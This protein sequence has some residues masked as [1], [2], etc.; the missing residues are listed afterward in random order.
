[1]KRSVIVVLSVSWLGCGAA[2]T[3]QGQA[4]STTHPN[5]PG[6]VFTIVFENEAASDVLTPAA[7]FFYQLSQQ[8]G[9]ALAYS[10]STHPSLPNY[11]MMTSGSTNGI[12]TDNDPAQNISLAGPDNL[13]AQLDAGN[14]MWRAYMESM[15]SPCTMASS[16]NYSAHHD[17]FLYYAYLAG[18]AASCAQHVVDY[19]QNFDADLA[20]GIYRYMWITPNMCD[21]MHNCSAQIADAWL[22]T[23]VTKIQASDAY[24]KGGAIIILFDEGS[25]RAPGATANLPTLVVSPLTAPAFKTSTPFDHRSYL[26][27]IED[28]FDL[29][30]LATTDAVN[31]MDE[32]FT[33]PPPAAQ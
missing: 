20:S 30:R 5:V 24:K 16:G 19:D 18:N 27:T 7:P 9:S 23:T 15:G 32:F 13:P 10:S 2:T 26:A 3:G 21:D 31:S 29:P 1:M 22:K 28:I 6:T 25:S 4:A 12:T 8:A 17:P 11:I 33:V 14:V